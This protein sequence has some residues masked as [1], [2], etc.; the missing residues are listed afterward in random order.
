VA[1]TTVTATAGFKIFFRRDPAEFERL[2][3]MLSHSLMDVMQFFLRV[4][5]TSRHGIAQE[6][7]TIFFK[8]GNFLWRERL[9]T[10]LFFLKG[11]ALGHQILVLRLGLVIGR[12]AVHVLARGAKI[13]IV[14]NRLAKLPGFQRYSGFFGHRL[15]I[16]S[17][18]PG[19]S[20]NSTSQAVIH[21]SDGTNANQ[22]S[23]VPPAKWQRRF[24]V[25][26]NS[27]SYALTAKWVVRSIRPMRPRFSLLLIMLAMTGLLAGCAS[28]Y[29][30]PTSESGSTFIEALA[31]V[32]IVRID[33]KAVP[34]VTLSGTGRFPIGPGPHVIAVQY[35]GNEWKRLKGWH[36]EEVHVRAAERSEGILS[37]RFVAERG[38]QYFVHAGVEG[39]LW[40]PYINETPANTFLDLPR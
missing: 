29:A 33:E 27:R 13:R 11:L 24:A 21:H 36:G 37:V 8:R 28:R 23:G 25:C 17:F 40:S 7:F 30:E 31:P 2:G 14:Q 15:H 39:S 6:R 3:N 16:F 12:E 18:G 22:C 38:H 19:H 4:Q 26:R 20:A 35:S 32:W 1:T 5:E 34:R 9:G 10:L